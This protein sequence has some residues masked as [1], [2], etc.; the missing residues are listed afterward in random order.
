MM[1]R[2]PVGLLIVFT[3]LTEDIGHLDALRRPHRRYR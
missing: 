1:K 3:V 2:H